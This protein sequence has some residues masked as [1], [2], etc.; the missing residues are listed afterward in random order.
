MEW[1]HEACYPRMFMQ[2]GKVLHYTTLQ[3]FAARIDDNILY[4]M[5]SSSMLLTKIRKLLV[6]IGASGFRSSNTSSCYTDRARIRKK[7][8]KLLI[9]A[10]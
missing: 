4:R 9:G 8:I 7:C 6:G 1:L 10:E 5:A 3:E 2:L